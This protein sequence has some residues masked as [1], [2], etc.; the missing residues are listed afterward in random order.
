MAGCEHGTQVAGVAAGNGPS[1][2]GVAR[3][4][5]LISI[6]VYSEI[7][8]EAICGFGTSSC[9]GAFTS[10]IIAG[11][12][13]VFELRNSFDIAAV[14]LS[15]GS[16]EL[17]SGSCDD[18]PEAEVISLLK[19]AGIA[20]VAA[21]GNSSNTSQMQS[22]AC[23]SDVIAVAASNNE[24]D[25]PWER[26]NISNQLDLFAPGISISSSTLNNDFASGTGTSFA[27]PHVAGALAVMKN[28]DPS[29]SVD[30]SEQLLKSVGPQLTQHTVTR[31][32]LSLSE[33]LEQ[34]D[35]P[36]TSPPPTTPTA[37]PSTPRAPTNTE[38]GF[39]PAVVV[40]LLGEDQ[41]S[42]EQSDED[43]GSEGESSDD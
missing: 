6:Q 39:L 30:A 7:N 11:L 31:R 41:S 26:N 37:P 21:T 5:N 3:D 2:D 25:S 38:I 14:N 9:I 24:A 34:I 32:F 33:V 15:L 22:P 28:A 10:D 35:A 42:D 20:V 19:S 1:F 29:L 36:V 40:I 43:Q 16:S 18:Q 12:E 17:F 8:D 4:A 13:R 23:I 27:T